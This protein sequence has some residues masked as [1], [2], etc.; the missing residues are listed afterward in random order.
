MSTWHQDRHPVRLFHETQWTV[1]IDPPHNMRSLYRTS[2]RELAEC[3][4]RGLRDNNPH[5]A[6]H[7]YILKPQKE[8]KR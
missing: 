6:E 3:Y 7:A 8:I 1:V 5:I 4:M 2:T